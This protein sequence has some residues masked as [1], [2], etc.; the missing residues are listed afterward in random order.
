M[1]VV[2]RFDLPAEE[3]VLGRVLSDLDDY[4]AELTQFVPTDEQFIPC[5]WIEADDLSA[6]ESCLADHPR[7]GDTTRFD[8]RAGRALYEIEWVAPFDD[9]L[10]IL[11]V[12]TVW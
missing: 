11:M 2:A 12:G 10:S 7:V 6:V 1:T 5:V 3:F 8:E 4:Y 9:L